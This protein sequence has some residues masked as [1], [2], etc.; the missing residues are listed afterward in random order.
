MTM[1]KN[2]C[3]LSPREDSRQ[4]TVINQA[5]QEFRSDVLGYAYLPLE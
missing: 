5:E 4:L 1:R 3:E 2:R